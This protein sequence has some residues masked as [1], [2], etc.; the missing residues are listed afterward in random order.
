MECE[1]TA[2]K[3]LKHL[4]ENSPQTYNLT[5]IPHFTDEETMT[6]RREMTFQIT[7]VSRYEVWDQP[8]SPDSEQ[9]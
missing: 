3:L 8:K 9:K 6:K 2:A 1:W 4:Q 5:Y 7:L